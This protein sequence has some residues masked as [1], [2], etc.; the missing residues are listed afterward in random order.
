MARCRFVR[1]VAF[2]VPLMLAAVVAAD[3]SGISG[4]QFESSPAGTQSPGNFSIGQTGAASY[5]YPFKL[6]PGRLVPSLGLVYSSAGDVH[7]NVASGWS[8]AGVSGIRRDVR[9]EHSATDYKFV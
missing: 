1:L 2:V 4:S 6:P 5:S 8:L 9:K 3:P 7:G